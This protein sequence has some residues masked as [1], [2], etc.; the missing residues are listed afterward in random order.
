[1][2]GLVVVG[3]ALGLLPVAFALCTS[4]MIG[5][6]PG[7]VA[8]GGDGPA[9]ER[10]VVLFLLSCAAFATQQVMAP[11]QAALGELMARRV[12]SGVNRR[13]MA[14]SLR[15][16]GLGP[17]E[18]AELLDELNEAGRELEY[19]YQT[20]GT[21]CSGL[22]ALVSRY[23][24]LVG[25]VVAIAVILSWPAAVTTA[26]IALMFRHGQRNGLREYSAVFRTLAA[27]RR[28]SDYLRRV[29]VEAPA[30]KEIRVFGLVRWLTRRYEE[31]YL[32][33]TGPVWSE[34][35]RIY[36]RPYVRYTV[37]ALVLGPPVLLLAVRGAA[38]GDLSL[39]GLALVVQAFLAVVRLGDFYPDSD[40][41]TQFGLNSY[42]SLVAFEKGAARFSGR[43]G[44]EAGGSECLEGD[45]RF[46]G[47]H[48]SY[49]GGREV[50]SGLD[51][52]IR[53]Q[54]STAIVGLN[55]SG[56]TTLV[57]LLARLHEPDAGAVRVAGT[58]LRSVPVDAWRGRM[59]VVFQDYLRYEVSAAENIGYGA[60]E[61][62]DD[63][64]GIVDAARAAGIA[65]VLEDLPRGYDTPLS[66]GLSGGTDLSGGQ[67]QRVA[68]A[69]A[70]F[71]ASHG[72]SV[73]V[74]DEPTASLDV[75]AEAK[76]H[77]EFVRLAAGRTMV[78]L[79]HRFST[80]RHADRIVV[81]GGGRV[82]EQGTHDELMSADGRYAQMFR[83]QAERF[84]EEAEGRE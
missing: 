31:A 1:V 12:D 46:D 19:G 80:V 42:T 58:D 47:V 15:P 67:W 66:S 62:L 32:A 40:M 45:I 65:Q 2:A 7:A 20:P 82:L 59:N 74:L 78:L 70:L 39:G 33:W 26:V 36:L 29:A 83:Y 9:W 10:L 81:L 22:F 73:L 51:L 4:A 77:E 52:T 75:R 55:G 5:A 23:I 71:A 28:K 30:A 44:R 27:D 84:T 61:H 69:R 34:R 25:F 56:K 72:S 57:K 68:I 50:F 60:V 35:R 16:S 54:R 79:S 3:V 11:V 76:F 24:Q 53:Q 17:L 64:E 63:R 21:A 38:A 13:L 41:Q 37:A 6:V 43:E 48:F 14:A 49:P 8:E 18:D